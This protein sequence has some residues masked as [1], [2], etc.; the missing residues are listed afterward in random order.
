PGVVRA[1]SRLGMELHRA[2]IELGEVEPLDGAVVERDVRR[3]LSRRRRDREA[4]VLAGDE[5]P[6]RTLVEHRVVRAAVAEAELEGLGAGREREQLVAEADSEQRNA[7][8]KRLHRRD[9][10]RERLRVAG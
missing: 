5:D 1:R 9:L 2:R 8:K 3:L 10:V 6:V 7:S 4:V